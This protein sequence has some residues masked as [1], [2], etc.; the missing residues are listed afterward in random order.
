LDFGVRIC[1]GFRVSDLEFSVSASYLLQNSQPS[2]QGAFPTLSLSTVGFIQ[3]NQPL[4]TP[5]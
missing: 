2:S 5:R 1:L 4:L 3:M